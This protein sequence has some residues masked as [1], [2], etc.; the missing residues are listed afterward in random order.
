MK[1]TPDNPN[2]TGSEP[3]WFERWFNDDYLQVY[4]HRNQ[5]E[6]DLQ[7]RSAL[8]LVPH[9][10]QQ[11][12]LD[13]GCGTGRHARALR[14][15]GLLVTAIDLSP[16]LLRAAVAAGGDVQFV[17]SDIRALPF[18][19]CCFELLTSFFTSFGYFATDS[20]HRVALQEW[21]RVTKQGGT[22][23]LDLPDRDLTIAQLQERTERTLS[24]GR[25]VAESRALSADAT[26]IEKI[27]K[28]GEGTAARQYHESVRLFSEEEILELL[29]AAGFRNPR[30]ARAEGFA[31]RLLLLAT[32][33]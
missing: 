24:D 1:F 27:I 25:K 32:G 30:R 8:T 29:H 5:S 28:I 21:A 7:V 6:A 14:A 33:S 13:L 26:R 3:A 12:C 11:N 9:A 20:E 31:G 23:L 17:R 22:L 19:D 4:P 10:L 16:T 15:A 18:R 2:A